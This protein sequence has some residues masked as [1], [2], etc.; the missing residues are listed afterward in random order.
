MTYGLSDGHVTHV[1]DDVTWPQRCCEAVRSATP[2][3]VGFL[4]RLSQ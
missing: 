1:N 4:L 2:A 3:T